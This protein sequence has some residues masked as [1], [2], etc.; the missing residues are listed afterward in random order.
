[1]LSIALISATMAS[2]RQR[3]E[4]DNARIAHEVDADRFFKLMFDLL[5][6]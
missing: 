3:G 1:M 2:A 6:D 5:R 4:R